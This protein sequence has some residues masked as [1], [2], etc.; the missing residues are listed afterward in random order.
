MGS[1]AN[2]ISSRAHG[3]GVK[4][5]VSEAA[6]KTVKMLGGF[7]LIVKIGQGGMGTVFRA[8][9]VSLDRE[10]ALKILPSRIAQKDPV[11]VERFIRE[12][13]TSAKLNHPNIVQ[14]IEVG[15][16]EATG[17]YYF[18]MEF[19]DGPTAKVL[20]KQSGVID[21]KKTLEISLGVA[22]ALVCAHRAGIVHRDI[23]P[24]NILL[25]QRGETKLADLGLA[26]QALDHEDSD[27]PDK[28]K[29]DDPF[30]I[31]SRDSELTQSGS[32]LGTPS[33]MAPEQIRGDMD[34][35]DARTDLYELGATM[36]HML[37]GKP[38]YV[39]A[40]SKAVMIMHLN[41]PV[42]DARTINPAVSESVS[43]LVSKLLQKESNKRCQSA[44][45][46]VREIDRIL[47][48]AGPERRTGKN[49]AVTGKNAPITGK[50]AQVG[51]RKYG[52]GERAHVA[53]N[54]KS[55]RLPK[56]GE[57]G[58]DV[59]KKPVLLFVGIG[60][61]LLCV[62]GVIA[63]MLGAG[64]QGPAPVVNSTKISTPEINGSSTQSAKP[65]VTV[66]PSAIAPTAGPG[67]GAGNPATPARP[68]EAAVIW[69]LFE[70]AR[71]A[72]REHPEDY[73]TAVKLFE[74]A[75]KGAPPGLIPDIRHERMAMERVRD[76]T[77]RKIL[78]ENVKK[79]NAAI[80]ARQ[81]FMAAFGLLQD[82]I[83]PPALLCENTKLELTRARAEIE[84]Q[85]AAMFKTVD[86]GLPKEVEAAGDNLAKLQA[87]QQRIEVLKKTFQVKTAQDRLAAV[88]AIV[89]D[90]VNKVSAMLDHLKEASFSM[91]VEAA[92]AAARNND[93]ANASAALAKVK[94]MPELAQHYGPKSDLLLC[95]IAGIQE[96]QKKA[97]DGLEAKMNSHE[98]LSIH[99]L[100]G[101][102]LMG[103][104]TS[105]DKGMFSIDDKTNG[106]QLIDG[107]R[108][109]PFEELDY[110][111]MK[112]DV[113]ERKYAAAAYF[114]WMGKPRQAYD[115]FTQVQKEKGAQ[116]DNAGIYIWWMNARA[117]E[118]MNKITDYFH[119]YHSN[120]TLSEADKKA[121]LN[122]ANAL[123]NRVKSDFSTTEAYIARKQKK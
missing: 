36:F 16:D 101:A 105:R 114:F 64:K 43:R 99:P 115:L 24:D 112:S 69:P 48:G 96:L 106:P 33:Y 40:N 35:I 49:A 58:A 55:G 19:I 87:L 66:A 91:A 108:L 11:F 77:F 52:A 34:K 51:E 60:A 1:I 88:A 110:A 7:E 5:A 72:A 21:E 44:E 97:I 100:G 38:P 57:D 122:E 50:N 63:M 78:E 67:P 89:A 9:Q 90:K 85:A 120:T 2:E 119:E 62:G 59:K 37:T 32:A 12:A 47:S 23:K 14:G 3:P 113:A 121:R 84:A 45:E 93:F 94:A 86:D 123:V 54:L 117:T 111:G 20:L 107:A 46:V 71:A 18:A 25:T 73:L 13:R 82:S 76:A 28:D 39:G 61:A 31:G 42:P 98:E 30:G 56:E 17:L 4:S 41:A 118:L 15:K 80:V 92:W 83:I 95:D 27:A 70:K 8:R 68:S 53:A 65:A 102:V 109:D 26:R 10:V 79:A 81:D 116:A 75:E 6:S 104:L 22:N 103:R 74:D 29:K